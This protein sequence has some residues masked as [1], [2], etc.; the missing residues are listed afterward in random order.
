MP[1]LIVSVSHPLSQDEALRRIQAT[2]AQAK[3]QYSDKI[4][5]LSE[6]WDDYVGTFI[7][8]AMKQKASGTVE[9][10][11]PSLAWVFKSRIESGIRD[12]LTRM[13]A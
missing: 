8:S 11:L 13:L 10:A 9:I 1:S 7:A 5:D 6:S 12:A 3:A 4:D 2:V